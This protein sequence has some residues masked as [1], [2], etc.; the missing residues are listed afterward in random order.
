[1]R[2]SNRLALLLA[3]LAAVV[4]TLAG[5]VRTL[6]QRLLRADIVAAEAVATL[7]SPNVLNTMNAPVDQKVRDAFAAAGKARPDDSYVRSRRALLASA[8]DPAVRESVR[9]GLVAQHV[10]LLAGRVP[11]E[12]FLDT[13]PRRAPFVAAWGTEPQYRAILADIHLPPTIRIGHGAWLDGLSLTMRVA[14]ALAPYEALLIA[15]TVLL[16]VAAVAVAVDRRAALRRT[17]GGLVAG[18]FVLYLLFDGL[19][20]IF[21][22]ASRSIEAE[23]AGRLYQTLVP[24]WLTFGVGLLVAGCILIGASFALARRPAAASAAAEPGDSDA[25]TART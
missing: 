24:G 5:V 8:A 10:A 11:S 19:V 13:T 4:A 7:T 6:D 12:L 20:A 25:A 14:H 17:G 18:A 9:R 2:R 22:R 15:L 23:V 21:F 1:M 3:V 16:A